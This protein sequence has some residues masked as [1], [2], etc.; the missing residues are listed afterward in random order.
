MARSAA[1]RIIL[2]ILEDQGISSI[3]AIFYAF[4]I[5]NELQRDKRETYLSHELIEECLTNRMS[6]S[7][8]L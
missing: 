8:P 3:S 7:M 4:N 5:S 2:S 6:M 1:G